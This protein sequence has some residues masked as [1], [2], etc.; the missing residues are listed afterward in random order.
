MLQLQGHCEGELWGLSPHPAEPTV[1]T[2][3]DD[4]YLRLW[5][6]KDSSKILLA[7]KKLSKPARSVS[8]N[9]DGKSIAVGFKDGK[10]N[11]DD[12]Q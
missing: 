9:S 4:G 7:F 8:I 12:I 6:F 2:A 5:S 3:S 1:A 10:L 11:S